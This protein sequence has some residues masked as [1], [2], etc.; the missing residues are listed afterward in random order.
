M[1]RT[2]SAAALAALKSGEI[3]ARDFVQIDVKLWSDNSDRTFRY[4]S[5]IENITASVIDPLTQVA[6]SFVFEGA[7]QLLSVQDVESGQG[8]IVRNLEIG[9]TAVDDPHL[10]MRTYNAKL[11]PIKLWRGLMKPGGETLLTPALPR[12]DGFVDKAQITYG[13]DGAESGVSATCISSIA[14]LLRTS[15]ATKSDKQ[16][17]LRSSTDSFRLHAATVEDWELFW[18]EKKG[19]VDS[20]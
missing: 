9:L 1:T 20:D 10:I 14:K 13:A 2:I 6:S 15:S 4:W 17:R 7:G 19:K 3:V 5:G 16:Q 18:G 8:L 12:F 11:A